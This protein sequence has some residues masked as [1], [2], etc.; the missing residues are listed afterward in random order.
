MDEEIILTSEDGGEIRLYVIEETKI[1]GINYLLA[2]DSETED[3]EAYILKDTSDSEDSD[4]LYEI[5]EDEDELVYLSKIFNE[6][7]DDEEIEIT[8]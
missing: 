7:L 2:S 3:G 5:V 6:L 1:G 8:L 4:A